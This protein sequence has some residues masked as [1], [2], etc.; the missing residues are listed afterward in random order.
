[1]RSSE[2]STLAI[3]LVGRSIIVTAPLHYKQK[4]ISGYRDLGSPSLPDKANGVAKRSLS[5][6]LCLCSPFL[7]TMRADSFLGSF[8][9][10]GRGSPY[11]VSEP[12]QEKERVSGHHLSLH[13]TPG[14]SFGEV[15]TSTESY[16]TQVSR[17]TPGPARIPE[18]QPEHLAQI[19]QG[20]S[21]ASTLPYCPHCYP[22]T[23]QAPRRVH[24]DSSCPLPVKTSYNHVVQCSPLCRG[25]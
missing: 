22:V 1:M 18:R 4:E 15:E 24:S 20:Q 2:A 12:P 16:K 11:W 17:K 7:L 25:C 21:G 3:C 9:G 8:K 14:G 5:S 6:C 23:E 13:T 19:P 10:T